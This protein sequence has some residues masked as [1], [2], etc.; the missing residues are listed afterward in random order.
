MAKINLLLQW[1]LRYS[2]QKTVDM[3]HHQPLTYRLSR[4]DFALIFYFSLAR[5]ILHII[6]NISGGYGLFRDELYYIACSNHLAAG[7]VDQ[8]PLS[9]FLL[10]AVTSVFGESLFAIRLI[11]AFAA[12]ATVFLTGLMV[13]R[14]GGKWR[15]QLIACISTGSLISFGMH[16][17]FSMNCIDFVVWALVCY[18][19]IRIVQ[20]GTRL[21][22]VILGVV[23]GLGLL[24]KIGVLFLGAGLFLGLILTLQRKWLLTPWPYMCGT[25]AFVLFS[26]YIFWNLQ[27]DM[28]HLE[29]IENASGGKY[30]GLSVGTFLIGNFLMVNPLAILVWLPGLLAL[31]LYKPFRPFMILGFLYLGPLVIL[32]LNGTSKAEYLA[33]GYSVLWAAGAVWLEQL[34]AQIKFPRLV[35]YTV[36]SLIVIPQLALM[37]L[38]IP[39]LPVT[40]Y[41][42]YA[43]AIGQEPSSAE[44][45]ELAELPQHYA[46][47]FGWDT[48]ARD[49]AKVYATLTD[50]EKTKCAIT[51]SNYGRCGAI[52]Y[53]GDAYGLPDAIGTHNNYWIWGPGKYTGEIMIIMGGQ[54]EHH[55]DDFEEVKL[56]GVSDCEYCMPYEDN[57]NIFICRKIKKPLAEVWPQEK[58]YD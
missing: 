21:H 1:K 4:G 7:Y 19:V 29:F 52:D 20:N 9:L 42:N 6:L 5:L 12:A 45:K 32:M 46:D 15:A 51:G 16:S 30:A 13:I 34:S 31:F 23:L 36:A 56:A 37:P 47:L 40:T 50:D 27:H 2:T 22:W 54:Y 26:P 57:M 48:K 10:K 18:I 33:P 49:V 17:Y 3:L 28:A 8:P 55:V 38:V 35:P 53:Y 43:D 39:I 25:I 58:H 14:L 24:N 11:P 41:M 44:N